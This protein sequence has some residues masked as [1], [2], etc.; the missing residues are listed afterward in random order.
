[1]TKK[2]ISS[3]GTSGSGP[4]TVC[5]DCGGSEFVEFPGQDFLFCVGCGSSR[6]SAA[7]AVPTRACPNANCGNGRDSDKFSVVRSDDAFVC[8]RCHALVN[9]VTSILP[10]DSV[11]VQEQYKRGFYYNEVI[12][13]WQLQEPPIPE[14]LLALLD[15]AFK[16]YRAEN[17]GQ[18]PLTKEAIHDICKSVSRKRHSAVP[19]SRWVRIGKRLSRRFAARR[20]EKPLQD[21]RKYG[22]KWRSLIWRWER[23]RPPIA[24]PQMLDSIRMFCGRVDIAFERVRHTP[25]CDGANNCHRRSKCRKNIF[26][27]SYILKKALLNC[28]GGNRKH[29]FYV[30]NKPWLPQVN[31]HQRQQIRQRFWDPI[32]R[33]CKFRHWINTPSHKQKT[34]H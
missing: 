13:Q 21:L 26:N 25:Q 24:T 3:Y 22:E 5:G 18:V 4:S 34:Y 19:T 8:E 23:R 16:A 15:N 31:K 20:T 27:T 33:Q 14:A 28:C 9:V 6:T 11:V 7:S 30:A 1:M 32:A 10:F 29:P 2:Q 17:P 12:S